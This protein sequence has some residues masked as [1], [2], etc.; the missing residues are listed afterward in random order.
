MVLEAVVIILALLYKTNM[1]NNKNIVNKKTNTKHLASFGRW[2]IKGFS[3]S[4]EKFYKSPRFWRIL[5]SLVV[6]SQAY[7]FIRFIGSTLLS[8]NSIAHK[9]EINRVKLSSE[10]CIDNFNTIYPPIAYASL[11]KDKSTM[12]ITINS[13]DNISESDFNLVGNKMTD[14]IFS[15]CSETFVRSVRVIYPNNRYTKTTHR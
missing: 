5:L 6:A 2:Y 14:A 15:T 7:S 13:T 11:N 8:G 12:I 4:H 9:S 3:L 10:L 1:N